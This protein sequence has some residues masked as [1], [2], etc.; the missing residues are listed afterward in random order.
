MWLINSSVQDMPWF[1]ILDASTQP[2][3]AATLGVNATGTI[4]NTDLWFGI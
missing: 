1:G 4:F 2:L 3:V